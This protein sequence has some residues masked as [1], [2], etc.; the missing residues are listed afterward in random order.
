MAQNLMGM[1]AQMNNAIKENPL[2]NQYNYS[3]P[4]MTPRPQD[5]M[6]PM[7]QGAVKGAG[8]AM[9]L[10]TDLRT[11]QQA[12]GDINKIMGK[13]MTSGDSNQLKEAGNLLIQQGR[14]VEGSQLIAQAQQIETERQQT[15]NAQLEAAGIGSTEAAQRSREKAMKV[16]ALQEASKQKDPVSLRALASGNLSPPDYYKALLAK[17]PDK[18]M[19]LPD[20]SQLRSVNGKLLAENPK[21]MASTDGTT[22]KMSRAG[23]EAMI[24]AQESW[25]KNSVAAV[26]LKDLSL[27]LGTT[28]F[29][30]GVVGDIDTFLNNAA[31]LDEDSDELKTMFW[32]LRAHKAVS[33]LPP[34]SASDKDVALALEGYPPKNS[35]PS[36]IQRWVDSMQKVA[37]L[38]AT[39]DRLMA[40]H[41]NANGHTGGFIDEV[42]MPY[43]AEKDS[44]ATQ[45]AAEKYR[46][47]VRNGEP[48]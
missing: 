35:S 4:G 22:R 32:E 20:G 29:K 28:D 8:G 9:G 11:S 33:N 14:V 15:F 36:R 5:T 3:V 27:R 24:G 37:Q 6:N 16:G 17:D 25:R 18:P 45:D 26:R 13:A 44:V 23:E 12:A 31:G 2:N 47:E 1:F 48:K 39:Y 46:L 10:P 40:R 30:G 38:T 43:L 7:L 41:I 34:G 21:D 42:W 19:V